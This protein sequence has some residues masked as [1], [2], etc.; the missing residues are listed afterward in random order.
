MQPS[1]LSPPQI[2]TMRLFWGVVEQTTAQSIHGLADADLGRYFVRQINTQRRLSSDEL[3]R[4]SRYIET[5]V[6]LIRDLT[7][8][9]YSQVYA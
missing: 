5:H 6:R 1:T 2:T 7:D 8:S 3:G 9:Q 4:L